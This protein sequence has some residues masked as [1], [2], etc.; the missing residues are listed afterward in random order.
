M[1]RIKSV[2]KGLLIRAVELKASD[3]HLTAN[4][5]PWVRLSGRLTLLEEPVL[6][7]EDCRELIFSAMTD[8]QKARWENDLEIDFGF[9][10]ENAARF[11]V[12]I[13]MQRG[14]LAGVFRVVPFHIRSLEEL[15]LPLVLK[16]L[17]KKRR[18]LVLVTGPS[19]SG[20][21]TTLAS[22]VDEINRKRR[23]HI[24]TLE[25]PIEFLHTPKSCLV[26]QREVH[27]DVRSFT[28][29]LRSILREDPDVVLIGELR[30][31]E[32]VTSALRIAETGH[33]TL[34]TLHTNSAQSTIQRIIGLFSPYQQEQIRLQLSGVLEGIVCQRLLPA[35]DARDCAVATEV[36]IPTTGIRNLIRD[37]KDHQ[38]YS[39][40]QTGQGESKMHTMN[41][42]LVE[43][44]VNRRIDYEAALAESPDISEMQQILQSKRIGWSGSETLKEERS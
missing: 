40:I 44:L 2:L 15:R 29:A 28:R 8:R 20:K 41:Q 12:N 42:S 16:D 4:S 30:D 19:G 24:I 6:S 21:S 27:S 33:L 7:E 31:A 34:A 22:M 36:L 5:A 11:R 17:A 13:F 32:T 26:S 38:I 1:K 43:L 10:I 3:L 35:A 39:L 23:G 18:G 9:G 14:H 37:K 25:D